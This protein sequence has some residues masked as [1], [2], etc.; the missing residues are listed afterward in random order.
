MKI[1]KVYA[2]YRKSALRAHDGNPLICALPEQLSP[3][4]LKQLL[5]RMPLPPPNDELEKNDRI[6]AVKNIRNILVPT[7]PFL[8]FYRAVY[9]LIL[10]GY[11]SRNPLN[12]KVVEWSYDIADP[13]VSIADLADSKKL[14]QSEE[15]TTSE[16]LFFAGMSGA[17][18]S[19]IKNSVLAIA[20]PNVIIHSREDFDDVQIVH[21]SV[22]MPHDGTRGTLLKN[23]LKAIDETLEGIEKTNFHEMAQPTLARSATIGSMESLLQSLCLKYHV[24]VIIVDEFQNINVASINDGDKMRQLFDSMSNLLHVPFVKIGTTDSLALFKKRFRHGRRAGETIE[25]LPYIKKTKS[26]QKMDSEANDKPTS[27]KDCLALPMPATTHYGKD[28]D[29]L[30]SALFDYQVIKNPI[31]YS[32]RWDEE[33]YKLSC[34]LPYVL[35]TLWEEAQIDA[36]RSGKETLTLQRLNQVYMRRFKLIKNALAAL[37]KNKTEHFRDLFTISQL[38][39]KG[40]NNA[41]LKHLENFT[42]KEQFSGVA[43]SGMLE[44]VQ[45]IEMNSTLDSE[46]KRKLE[47]IKTKLQQRAQTIEKGQTL[48]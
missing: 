34:G 33:L 47:S 12:P 32:I 11:E 48:G 35:F 46:Q 4:R 36:I 27:N 24:G 1:S 15:D 40:D 28:W 29:N 3:G 5:T 30:L 21:L 8:D 19:E 38:I 2:Q 42:N 44:S 39:D 18:K 26:K 7:T 20:F 17:G 37:R 10:T 16:H 14:T 22:E 13:N 41:A 9:N 23:L 6:R 25:L 45:N 43:A 31:K